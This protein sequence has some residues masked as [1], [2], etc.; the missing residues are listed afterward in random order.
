MPRFSTSFKVFGVALSVKCSSLSLAGKSGGVLQYTMY[1]F[2]V[3]LVGFYY[4]SLPA[5][6]K[7]CTLSTQIFR[8][9]R[10]QWGGWNIEHRRIGLHLIH[11]FNCVDLVTVPD[12]MGEFFKMGSTVCPHILLTKKQHHHIPHQAW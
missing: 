9:A 4:D 6:F 11:G 8:A 3:I 5:A 12:N 10:T 1:E 2:L 7:C